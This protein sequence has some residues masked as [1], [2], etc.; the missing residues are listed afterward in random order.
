MDLFEVGPEEGHKDDQRAGTP[1]LGE[2]AVQSEEE[3]A[4]GRPYYGLS[5][6]KEGPMEK[7]G[8]IFLARPLVTGQGVKVLN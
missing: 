4:V 8:T 5:V 6:L 7:V 2:K 3:K 1:L